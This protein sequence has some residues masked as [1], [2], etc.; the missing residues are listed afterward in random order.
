MN[1]EQRLELDYKI[2]CD[3]WVKQVKGRS[4]KAQD[5]AKALQLTRERLNA[6]RF[7]N[8]HTGKSVEHTRNFD[9]LLSR[10][11]AAIPIKGKSA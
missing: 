1:L 9:L 4:P 10:Q 11:Y 3:R 5:T 6:E 2:L 8:S 7:K